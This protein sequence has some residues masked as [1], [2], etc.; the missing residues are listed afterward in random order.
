MDLVIKG[1]SFR[2]LN[3]VLGR[4]NIAM[5]FFSLFF[6]EL[7]FSFS[8]SFSFSFFLSVFFL[9]CFIDPKLKDMCTKESS[10]KIC[11]MV[12]GF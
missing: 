3:K 12:K 4:F 11:R 7:C 8:F 10:Q 9:L 5:V 1:I 6:L 2:M